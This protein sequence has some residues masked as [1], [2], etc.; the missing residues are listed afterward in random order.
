M[1]DVQPSR[2]SQGETELFGVAAQLSDG[3]VQA[4]LTE[5][6]FLPLSAYP[7]QKLSACRPWS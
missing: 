7:A 4:P 3:A 5:V 2:P 1:L 6:N